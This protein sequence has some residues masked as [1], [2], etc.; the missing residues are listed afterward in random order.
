VI[1]DGWGHRQVLEGPVKWEVGRTYAVQPGRGKKAVGRIRIT[2][3]RREKLQ[4]IRVPDILAEGVLYSEKARSHYVPFVFLWDS[5]YKKPY[6]WE[7]NP[8]VWVREFELAEA[9]I[10]TN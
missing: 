3:I 7:D 10:C 8:E 2:K 1:R 6:R 9:G 5:I 4:A